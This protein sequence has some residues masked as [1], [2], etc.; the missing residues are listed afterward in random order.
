MTV[1]IPLNIKKKEVLPCLFKYPPH[2]PHVFPSHSVIPLIIKMLNYDI[3]AYIYPV[4]F[5]ATRGITSHEEANRSHRSRLSSSK[6]L[7]NH[8]CDP[9]LRSPNRNSQHPSQPDYHFIPDACDTSSYTTH[10]ESVL[11]QG[12]DPDYDAS[13][14]NQTDILDLNQL[15]VCLSI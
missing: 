15:K 9:P 1:Y 13:N 7:Q 6:K 5:A 11:V 12:E 14:N 10:T 8:S 2:N 4:A 3:I